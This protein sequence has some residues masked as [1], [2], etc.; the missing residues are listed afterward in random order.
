MAVTRSA[1]FGSLVPLG[2]GAPSI[3]AVPFRLSI[4]SALA[5]RGYRL[6]AVSNF[7][8]SPSRPAD[9]GKSIAASDIGVG[10]A[11]IT[12]TGANTDLAVTPG[13]DYDPAAVRGANGSSHYAG[14]AA[15]RANLADLMPG[16]DILRVGRI[17]A[18]SVRGTADLN[19]TLKL[20]VQPQFLTPGGFSGM[21]TLVAAESR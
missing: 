15:G 6:T 20:V 7:V 21:I 17:P 1:S 5:V 10:L 16:R 4:P 9:G 2:L 18:G 19:L 13:F 3:V 12:L 8:F 11:G 14:A